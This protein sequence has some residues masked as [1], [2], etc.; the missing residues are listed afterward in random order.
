MIERKC[1][2]C[3]VWNND[4]DYCKSCA[5]PLSPKALDKVR[6]DRIAEEERNK[7]P[8]KTEVFLLKVKKS[9]FLLV[10]WTYYFFYS[11]FMFLG[12]IGAMFAWMA[13]LA[14]A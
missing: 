1:L 12:A 13:A 4:E 6:E 9:R 7:V 14:N 2:K 11:I 10:R 3:G 8:S 5:E